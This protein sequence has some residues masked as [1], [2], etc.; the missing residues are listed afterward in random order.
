V[1]PPPSVLPRGEAP[2]DAVLLLEEGGHQAWREAWAGAVRGW[3]AG[4]AREGGYRVLGWMLE[5]SDA[6][7]GV[8]L[9]APLPLP[10][11]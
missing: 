4:P 11:G 6:A 7:G 5:A 10:R 2:W 8:A 1:I 3:L 9:Q